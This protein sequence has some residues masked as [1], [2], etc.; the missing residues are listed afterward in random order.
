MKRKLISVG[1]CI[2]LTVTSTVTG[3]CA[4]TAYANVSVNDA[5]ETVVAE[6]A[7][8][9]KTSTA[10]ELTK[11]DESLWEEK[12]E[13]G[14]TYLE[15]SDKAE[16]KT[17][18]PEK[19]WL[20]FDW[21]MTRGASGEK[22][23]LKNPRKYWDDE[24]TANNVNNWN[25]HTVEFPDKT[26]IS[27]L[28]AAS[29]GAK[30]RLSNVRFTSAQTPITC[31]VSGKGSV[32]YSNT[33]SDTKLDVLADPGSKATL[34]AKETGSDIF[35]AWKDSNGNVLSTSTSYTFDVYDVSLSFIALFS[36]QFEE[37]GTEEDP[38][39]IED[40][41]DI[42]KLSAICEGGNSLSGKYFILQNDVTVNSSFKGI[43]GEF[44]GVFDGNGKKIS[45]FDAETSGLFK[46]LG[47]NSE[48]KNLTVAN[49]KITAS[50][51]RTG[52]I[53]G[54]A[55]GKISGCDVTGTIDANYKQIG[56][57][58]GYLSGSIENS[59]FSGTITST[60][61]SGYTNYA[62]GGIAGYMGM[63]AAINACVASGKITG[64]ETH[65]ADVGG[66]VGSQSTWAPVTNCISTMDITGF[67]NL[68]GIV[69]G[70]GNS[71]ISK[72]YSKGKISG[73]TAVGGII[74]NN[75]SIVE[76]SECYSV[77]EVSALNG[78]AGGIIGHT[79]YAGTVKKVTAL[80]RSVTGKTVGRIAGD[81]KQ[82]TWG[83]FGK[84]EFA[85]NYA[86][87]LLSLIKIE[88]EGN[89]EISPSPVGGDTINGA[90]VDGDTIKDTTTQAECFASWNK[91]AWSIEAGKLPVLKAINA[92]LQ[93]AGLPSYISGKGETPVDPDPNPGE[94]PA[95][96]LTAALKNA[97]LAEGETDV[98]IVAAVNMKEA[99]GNK[100]VIHKG[101]N[102]TY[103][104]D[105]YAGGE[106][107]LGKTVNGVP[108]EGKDTS[109][110]SF[111]AEWTGPGYLVFDYIVMSKRGSD[112]FMISIDGAKDEAFAN[113][114]ITLYSGWETGVYH[115][116]GAADQKH[117]AKITYYR[118]KW[119]D[120]DDQF[121]IFDKVRF[122]K[123]DVASLPGI[124]VS[125]TSGADENGCT[126]TSDAADISSVAPGSKVTLTANV[127]VN[128]GWIFRG[129]KSSADSADYISNK[130][131][132]EV[133]VYS[134]D[135]NIYAEY[136]KPF[137]G[138]GTVESPYL[139]NNYNDIKK[140]AD[141]INDGVT[142]EGRYLKQTADIDMLGKQWVPAGITVSRSGQS[143]DI[144]TFGGTYDGAGKTILNM[145][146]VSE[147]E[148]GLFG[149]TMAGSTIK[150]VN[151]VDSQIMATI[152]DESV[153]N[154]SYVGFIAACSQSNISNCTVKDSKASGIV[155][156]A[157]ITGNSSY[158]GHGEAVIE[159]CGVENTTIL[160]TGVWDNAYAAGIAGACS[161]TAIRNC[162]FTGSATGYG[163]YVAGIT[164]KSFSDITGCYV[165]A[166]ITSY[167][168]EKSNI[169]ANA[170][171]GIVATAPG[172]TVSDCYVIG[173]ITG[174]RL[175]VGGIVGKQ[176][177]DTK[178]INCYV[179]GNVKAGESSAGGISGSAAKESEDATDSAC[180]KNSLYIGQTVTADAETAAVSRIVGS[181]NAKKPAELAGNYAF[182]DVKLVSAGKDAEV[183]N[184]G[185][186]QLNGADITKAQI[187]SAPTAAVFAD[188]SRDV[189]NIQAGKL[190]TLKN[191]EQSV[192]T[193][194]IPAYAK[195]SS[196]S[197][198]GGSSSGGSSSGG[199]SGTTTPTTPGQ[200]D[201]NPSNGGNTGASKSFSDVASGSWY[202]DAVKYVSDKGIM[203]GVSDKLFA[204]E[205]KVSRAMFVQ[206]LY[207]MEKKPAVN[208]AAKFTDV[209]QSAWYADAVAWAASNGIVTGISATEFAPE[210]DV[211]REQFA[212]MLYRYASYKGTLKAASGSFAGFTDSA[213]VSSYA[214]EALNWAI[215]NGIIT[216]KSGNKLDPKGGATRA[217]A[218][219]MMMRYLA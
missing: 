142:Y 123:E 64:D 117:T 23:I 179:V 183:T 98:D 86:F 156:V 35:E 126:V 153:T 94:D 83:D 138:N 33:E 186:D 15:G 200:D 9:T 48:V 42:E 32:A 180:V 88:N 54:S 122:V 184:K 214:S 21:M 87:S 132:Y 51:E 111:T 133:T 65:F 40:Q 166:D 145:I 93:D 149:N 106:G 52:I 198:G 155:N 151:I 148:A 16:V 114:G 55:N 8:A 137:E 174:G 218:A 210:K 116:D 103:S 57:I 58:A 204:P 76:L 171:G 208:S 134:D 140:M 2:M 41:A 43:P 178:V 61:A 216:G 20:L 79:E 187:N 192:Q 11:T 78:T 85:D 201:Q 124:N 13:D 209:K 168:S 161:S 128:K 189:W 92:E 39:K 31:D 172:G 77:A 72:C 109:E 163:R 152:T 144:M 12:T 50:D 113:G 159:N 75:A 56:G 121:V 91:D 127:D 67:Q 4:D 99:D 119:G 215:G 211:T 84:T 158:M 150:N 5:S 115:V 136:E 165:K 10:L 176:S 173:N 195:E 29:S 71:I 19:G 202:N 47:E 1:V 102:S 193:G 24:I 46:S 44:N 146:A 157:G 17:T 125:M 154:K 45:G 188:W 90:N 60:Y 95:G 190:P 164:G 139:I 167:R 30:G 96:S 100:I 143:I 63:E 49:A 107:L 110:G 108:E 130:T 196:S 141:D 112:R 97:L 175:N 162:Y 160:A 207:N 147:I 70:S 25:T 26:D 213:A 69:G 219:A 203:N 131:S 170:V 7:A 81:N 73:D 199:N 27:W 89:T 101:G 38:Y 129:W 212:V 206:I 62:T 197:G 18:I 59:S 135:I 205:Q 22:L 28:V 177:G 194:E 169:D 105:V 191:I 66:I 3:V 120:D 80:N 6:T 82:K 74:G 104:D 37:K 53:A 185:A 14:R 34:T 36:S 217:E 68:G 181:N 182:V 118:S